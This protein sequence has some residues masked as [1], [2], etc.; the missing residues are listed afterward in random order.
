MLRRIGAVLGVVVLA[1]GAV[2]VHTTVAT[3]ATLQVC[4]TITR[5]YMGVVHSARVCVNYVKPARGISYYLVESTRVW[6]PCDPYTWE[7]FAIMKFWANNGAYYSVYTGA[8]ACGHTYIKSW[9]YP[10]VDNDDPV[11]F[12]VDDYVLN[13]CKVNIRPATWEN[14]QNIYVSGLCL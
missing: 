14:A 4:H 7:Q 3:A 9:P 2:L 13:P 1:F 11:F 5:A 10:R 12:E 8:I 6:N